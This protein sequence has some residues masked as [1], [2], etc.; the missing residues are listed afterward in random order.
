MQEC[1]HLASRYEAVRAVPIVGW[2]IASSG[3]TGRCHSVYVSF[4]NGGVV[5]DEEVPTSVVGVS[6]C[7]NQESSHLL[8]GYLSFRAEACVVRRVASSC[9]SRCSKLFEVSLRNRSVD[10]YGES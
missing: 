5:V 6:H 7:S 1:R 9:D 3:D 4:E 10:Y 2:G 8:S